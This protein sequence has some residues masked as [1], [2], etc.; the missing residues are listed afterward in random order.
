MVQYEGRQLL[1]A[2]HLV[3]FVIAT[4]HNGDMKKLVNILRSMLRLGAFAP[5]VFML[6][7]MVVASNAL[8]SFSGTL[9]LAAVVMYLLFLV[10]LTKYDPNNPSLPNRSIPLTTASTIAA[11]MLLAHVFLFGALGPRPIGVW[12]LQICL[13]AIMLLLVLCL[14]RLRHRKTGNLMFAIYVLMVANAVFPTLICLSA[15]QLPVT[16]S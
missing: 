3:D 9:G 12:F 16:T 8:F 2:V 5:H 1:D 4:A 14:L 11:T 15:I 7:T 6:L 13:I 10:P